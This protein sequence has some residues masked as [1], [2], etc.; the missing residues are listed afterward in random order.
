MLS[1]PTS[2]R[3]PLHPWWRAGGRPATFVCVLR[4]YELVQPT[5]HAACTTSRFLQ[6][7]KPVTKNEEQF[8]FS[9]LINLR[10]FPGIFFCALCNRRKNV[11]QTDLYTVFVW[12]VC[13]VRASKSWVKKKRKSVS[14]FRFRVVGEGRR[15][16]YQ[17]HICVP[18]HMQYTVN[19]WRQLKNIINHMKMGL[20]LLLC[21]MRSL[22]KMYIMLKDCHPCPSSLLLLSNT[23]SGAINAIH[24]Q[25][26][27]LTHAGIMHDSNVFMLIRLVIILVARL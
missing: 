15:A 20:L 27:L 26:I 22:F 11:L 16:F 21:A 7:D 5:A 3:K 9:F 10:D 23:N 19:K 14:P 13:V 8:S 25:W 18:N 17:R 2:P 6:R 24:I 1:V 12:C 4:T